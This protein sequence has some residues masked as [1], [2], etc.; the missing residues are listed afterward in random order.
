MLRRLG[1]RWERYDRRA[2][3]TGLLGFGKG[4]LVGVMRGSITLKGR[5][6]GFRQGLVVGGMMATLG[7]PVAW[8]LL[9]GWV[10]WL[11]GCERGFGWYARRWLVIRRRGDVE[12]WYT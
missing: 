11:F 5:L 3:E 6:L 4:L 9:V 12:I 2:R 10:R 1:R 7:M 8:P